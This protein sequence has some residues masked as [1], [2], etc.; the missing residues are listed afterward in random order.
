VPSLLSG[1]QPA[2]VAAAGDDATVDGVVS[3]GG[4]VAAM[5][6]LV[7]FFGRGFFFFLVDLAFLACGVGLEVAAWVG[8]LVAAAEALPVGVA[9]VLWLLA[10]PITNS[11]TRA[12]RVMSAAFRALLVARPVPRLDRGG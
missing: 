3:A 7:V 8:V 9:F 10:R 5:A 12:P 4:G 1:E 6:G 11:R 2:G